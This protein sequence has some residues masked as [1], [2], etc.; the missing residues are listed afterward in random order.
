MRARLTHCPTESP[1][2]GHAGRGWSGEKFGISPSSI[3]DYLAL[4][5]D[6][7]DGYPG[8]RGWGA[9]SSAAV[10]AKY[11]HLESIPADWREWHV[12][13]ASAGA[14]ADTL[15]RERDRALLF[16]TLA[17]LRTDLPLFKDVEELRWKGATSTFD[18]LAARLDAAKTDTRRGLIRR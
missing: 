2:A 16:R 12:N 13:A 8:L 18:A 3:P 7:A 11:V 14:L 9:K 10:L 6:S 15:N 17:R 1:D 4:V 5:G